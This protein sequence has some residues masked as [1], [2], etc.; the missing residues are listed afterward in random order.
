[1][2]PIVSVTDEDGFLL[3][4]YC[5]SVFNRSFYNIKKDLF[6]LVMVQPSS[7]LIVRTQKDI[8]VYIC[9]EEGL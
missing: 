1:M 6:C 9:C 2:H 5:I 3:V 4:N 7:V 8:F